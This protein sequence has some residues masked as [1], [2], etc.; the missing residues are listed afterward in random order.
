MQNAAIMSRGKVI[1]IEGEAHGSKMAVTVRLPLDVA[2]RLDKFR[3]TVRIENWTAALS[4][5]DAIVL[6]VRRGLPEE[7]KAPWVDTRCQKGKGIGCMFRDGHDGICKDG[8]SDDDP[9]PERTRPAR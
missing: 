8:I 3:Q 5:S 2:E 1:P 6:L 4:R 9:W 7:P